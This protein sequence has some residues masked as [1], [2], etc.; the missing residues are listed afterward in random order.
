MK[1]RFPVETIIACD[2]GV[3]VVLTGEASPA[4]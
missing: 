4:L 1:Q 2:V 3:D